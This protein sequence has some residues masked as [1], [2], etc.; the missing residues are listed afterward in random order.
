MLGQPSRGLTIR[1]RV[2]PKLPIARAAMPMFSPSCGSTRT[3]TGPARSTPDLVLS[4]P[5]PDIS[6]HFLTQRLKILDEASQ[7]LTLYPPQAGRI[8]S[9]VREHFSSKITGLVMVPHFRPKPQMRFAAAA[10][11]HSDFGY[12]INHSKNEPESRLQRR[13][14]Y[15]RS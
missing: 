2:S 15:G 1:K 13:G 10:C 5:D 7:N 3:T 9:P 11:A 4:V 8:R 6:L 14:S 12:G